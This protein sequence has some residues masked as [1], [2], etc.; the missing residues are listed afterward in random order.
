M[1]YATLKTH[2]G[3]IDKSLQPICIGET[4]CEKT[5]VETKLAA[6][7]SSAHASAVFLIEGPFKSWKMVLRLE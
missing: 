5:L 3:S 2:V 7:M 1:S 6:C 4:F